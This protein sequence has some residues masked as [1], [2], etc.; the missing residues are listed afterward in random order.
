M[1]V[2]EGRKWLKVS[3]LYIILT[4]DTCHFAVNFIEIY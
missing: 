4:F 2:Q 1:D 3:Y